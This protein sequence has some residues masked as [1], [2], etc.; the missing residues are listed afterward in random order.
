[1]EIKTTNDP[2]NRIPRKEEKAICVAVYRCA[3]AGTFNSHQLQKQKSEGK[4]EG[5]A[6]VNNFSLLDLIT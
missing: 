6:K 5:D 3:A 1:M 2:K 4:G